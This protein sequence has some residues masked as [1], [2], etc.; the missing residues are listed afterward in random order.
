MPTLA[1][2]D[3]RTVIPNIADAIRQDLSGFRERRRVQQEK[4]DLKA[5]LQMALGIQTQ[6]E[7][8]TTGPFN[9][10]GQLAPKVAQLGGQLVRSRDAEGINRF[11]SEAEKGVTLAGEISQLPTHAAKLNRLSQEVGAVAARGGDVS[12]LVELSQLSEAELGLE[13]QKMGVIGN[14]MLEGVQPVAA[15]DTFKVFQN[16]QRRAAFA[17]IAAANPQ[18]ANMILQGRE[19]QLA[20]EERAAARARAERQAAASAAAAARAP[21]TELGKKAAAIRADI[22]SGAIGEEVG[23]QLL[24]N[25]RTEA[26]GGG[27]LTDILNEDGQIIAQRNPVTNEITDVPDLLTP[28]GGDNK[29]SIETEIF[30]DGSVIQATESGQVVVRNPAGDVVEGEARIQVLE[31]SKQARRE[32]ERVIAA[33]KAAGEAA[34][35]RSGEAFDTLSK[36]QEN[37]GNLNEV[38]G[39]I[40]DGA[41]SGPINKL[42]PNISANAVALDNARKKL[43]LD[44]VGGVTFGALSEGELALALDVALPTGLPPRELREHVIARRDAQQKLANELSNAATFLGTPGNTVAGFLEQQR[45]IAQPTA[46]EAPAQAREQGTVPDRPSSQEFL[47]TVPNMTIE[48]IWALSPN[49][50]KLTD[51]ELGAVIERLNI[52]EGARR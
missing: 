21:K 12:R 22:A 44:V 25:L 47:A 35:K 51:E 37:I 39:L 33:E 49:F 52:L 43:G 9:V 20:A 3:G 40:D 11:R 7:A 8:P 16:P 26:I 30:P 2:F 48:E 14:A 38:V 36:V 6:E 27:R 41:P 4:D 13:L 45:Q 50:D 42:L 31:Q 46:Q 1:G 24:E 18:L 15:E 34:I 32:I 23:T 10:L 28:G 29:F 5:N 17:N 19:R